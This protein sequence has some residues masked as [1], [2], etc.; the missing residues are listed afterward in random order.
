[1]IN[2]NL[3]FYGIGRASLKRR[4]HYIKL[5]KILKKNFKVNKIE[6]LNNINKIHNLRSKEFSKNLNRKFIF[7]D[8]LRIKEKFINNKIVKN[9][10]AISM[11]YSDVH[12]DNY[13]STHN[14]LQQLAMLSTSTNYCKKG[15]TL[16][17]RDDLF[18]NEKLLNF[19]VN[20]T[21]KLLI[22]NKKMFVTSFFH[23]NRGIC[24]RFY[25][26][27]FENGAQ[28]LKRIKIVKSFLKNAKD[29]SYAH[30]KGL[31]GEWLIRYSVEKNK[32][33]PICV[34]LFTK[35]LR[36]NFV[37]KEVLFSSPKHWNYENATFNGLFRYFKYCYVKNFFKKFF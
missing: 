9:L 37:Q 6:V 36:L 33:I 4:Y 2:L 29:L 18:F 16:A 19:Y 17:I 32:L 24:D 13:I 28:L 26:G 34:P 27:S 35:R 31:N 14:L 20:Q 1:M 22:K 15:L 5:E 11:N 3:I 21:H 7:K 8:S 10:L 30:S 12:L 25:F 23:S